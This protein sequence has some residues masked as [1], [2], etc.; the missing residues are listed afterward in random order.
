MPYQDFFLNAGLFA[1][2]IVIFLIIFAESGLFFGFFLPGDSLLISLGLIAAQGTLNIWL[3]ILIGVAAAISGDSV[4]YIF[5]KRV[6]PALFNKE[7]SF[8]FKKQY[9]HK[10]HK[11]Y[12]E[13]GKLTIVLARFTPFVRTFAPIVAGIGKMEYKTFISYNVIGGVSWIV[14]ISLTG[15]FLGTLI[16]DIDRYILPLVAVI[17]IASFI[18]TIKHLRRKS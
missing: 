7:D 16:P 4:G 18:P 13:H 5:G 8:I 3:I 9:V 15:Y 1:S 11:F 6:G 12:E 14:S 2:Y 10:A 17:V